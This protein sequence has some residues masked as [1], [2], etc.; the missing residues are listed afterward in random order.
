M[1]ITAIA[2]CH[3]VHTYDTREEESQQMKG[4]VLCIRHDI[5]LFEALRLAHNPMRIGLEGQLEYRG[6]RRHTCP[7]LHTPYKT[8]IKVY[9]DIDDQLLP[10][11]L[12]AKDNCIVCRQAG[13]LQTA[14]RRADDSV[15]YN[16]SVL[17]RFVVWT[18]STAHQTY[19]LTPIVHT[20][21]A[22]FKY[23]RKKRS[24]HQK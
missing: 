20:H 22:S 5:L 10:A 17:A 3:G 6:M 11:L 12:Y 18:Q 9:S 19:R 15:S 16:I 7:L 24:P 4:T 13:L 23:N 2:P 21:A 8:R 14:K 1:A